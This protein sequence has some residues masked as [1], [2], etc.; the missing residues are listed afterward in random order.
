MKQKNFRVSNIQLNKALRGYDPLHAWAIKSAITGK[1]LPL[2]KSTAF[3]S[4]NNL[5]QF[6]P[7]T[8]LGMPGFPGSAQLS[9]TGTIFKNLRYFLVSNIRTAVSQAYTEFGLVQTVIDVPVDDALRGGVEIKSKQLNEEQIE[10]LQQVLDREDDLLNAGQGAKWADLFGG[11]G[12]L[13]WISDQDPEEPLDVEAITED[14][15]IKFIPVDM[16]ELFWGHL[17]DE[18]WDPSFQDQNVEI[19]DYY[20]QAVH[21]SRVLKMKGHKAPSWIRPRLRGWGTSRLEVLVRSI[22]RYLKEQD[23]IFEILDEFKVDYYSLEG[24]AAALGTAAGTKKTLERL[25]IMNQAKNYNNAVIMDG[26][27]KFEQKQLTFSGLAD[28]QKGTMINIAADLRMPMTKIFGIS[29]AGFNSGEDDIEVYN[30]MVESGPRHNLKRPILR[31]LEIRCQQHF[32][33]I[34]DDLAITFKPLRILS[35][36]DEEDCKTQ[37]FTRVLQGRQANELTSL[38]FREVVNKGNLLPIQLETDEETL[39]ALESQKTEAM[40]DGLIGGGED[41]D[42]KKPPGGERGVGAPK[43]GKIPQPKKND[44]KKTTTPEVKKALNAD[45]DESKHPRADDGKF[46]DKGGGVAVADDEEKA[47]K[48][49]FNRE[50]AEHPAMKAKDPATLVANCIV[51][52]DYYHAMEDQLKRAEELKAHP[53]H[54]DEVKRQNSEFAKR[55]I[56]PDSKPPSGEAPHVVIIL[57]KTGSGKSRLRTELGY[58]ADHT[59]CDADEAMNF[60]PGYEPKYAPNYHERGGDI[61]EANLIPECKAQG[62]NMI[63][64]M[65]GKNIDKMDRLGAVLKAAGYRIEVHLANVSDL[66]AGQRAFKRFKKGKRFVAVDYAVSLGT[67]PKA[68]Y[69]M[70]MAKYAEKGAEHDTAG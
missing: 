62:L 26:K 54:P 48:E 8:G 27:D 68:S 55:M 38:E 57:G 49:K 2:P 69:D 28:V 6:I 60:I 64:D 15:E 41:G 5:E 34:P 52:R 14:S 17:D 56:N 67:K 12:N 42:G 7:F 50:M 70:L 1:K 16:W 13:I 65:T 61:V 30:A 19:F 39:E 3:N 43:E 33:F 35:A 20:G 36:K 23:V 63:L 18:G 31:M 9:N 45:W 53:Q 4:L 29:A 37:V 59:I 32:G 66:M 47:K 44:A 11:G 21:K 58:D 51:D 25:T 40:A 10:E 46:G 22:N 24:L